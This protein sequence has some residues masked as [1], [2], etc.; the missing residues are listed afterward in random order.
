MNRW[1]TTPASR[2]AFALSLLGLA[3]LLLLAAAIV[4]VWLLHRYYDSHLQSKARELQTYTVLN[5]AR[6][7][8]L[9]AV[10]TLKE[11][12]TKKFFLKGATPALASAELQDVVKSVV[13]ANGGR[14]LSTQAI[15][16]K[17]DG[18]Y[19]QVT[20]MVQ[21]SL[22]IQS[23]RKVLYTLESREPYLFIDNLKVSSLMLAVNL[24]PNPG[25]EPEMSVQMDVSGYTAAT[26]AAPAAGAKS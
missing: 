5:D 22:N 17:D 10:E 15:Q 2:R 21:L 3:V 1:L 12:D 6:P 26:E 25:F 23:L 14:V 7:K 8:M 16:H 18:S 24:K 13:E 9:K 11:R 4:P 19:R 20:T